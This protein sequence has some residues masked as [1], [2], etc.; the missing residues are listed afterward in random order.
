M[1]APELKKFPLWKQAIDD[2][3]ALDPQPG[4]VL[5]EQWLLDHLEMK[6]PEYGYAEEFKRWNLQWLSARSAF[7]DALREDHA[8][9]FATKDER[10]WRLLAQGEVAKVALARM[11]H[12]LYKEL[13][14]ARSSLSCADLTSMTDAERT[15]NAE[16]MTRVARAM[17]I[18]REAVKLPAPPAVQK[19]IQ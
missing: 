8:M 7:F 2:F 12:E 19:R 4:F 3:L 9:Q 11:K 14:R 1:M 13:R 17:N 15:E 6:M 5:E 10:G 18:A 16:A